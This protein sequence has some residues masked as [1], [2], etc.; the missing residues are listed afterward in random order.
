MIQIAGLV[1]FIYA[2]RSRYG[3]TALSVAMVVCPAGRAASMVS[4]GV[5]VA[6]VAKGAAAKM[7][8]AVRYD[9]HCPVAQL[10]AHAKLICLCGAE[11]RDGG[12]RQRADHQHDDAAHCYRGR[13]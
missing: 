3:S 12:R 5:M 10:F 6:G 13:R 1:T 8:Q 11:C 7:A 4:K 2:T 9:W